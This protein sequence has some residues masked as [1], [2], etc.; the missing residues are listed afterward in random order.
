MPV[1][2]ATQ[3]YSRANVSQ[4]F[5]SRF[6][7]Y[8]SNYDKVLEK[9]FPSAMHIYRVFS[10]GVKD[11]FGDMKMYFKINSIVNGKGIK[12]LT[13]KEMELYCQM[14]K[15]M[16]KVAPVLLIAALPFMNYVIFPIAYMYPRKLLTSHFWTIQQRVE[17]QE[18]Y[19][20]ERT[21][22]NKKLFRRLQ[23][24]LDGTKDSP[25][26]K[27]FNYMLGLLGSGTHPTAEE[28][29]MVKDVFLE[30]PYSL[31]SLSSSHLVSH[32]NILTRAL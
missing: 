5:F 20:K 1:K 31:K 30:A 29:L 13:R 7:Q 6:F 16:L 26:H 19:L 21:A 8:I 23:L 24:G 2:D 32:E 22:N 12:A 4:Y 3:K 15:D 28:I 27:E 9:K 14:P 18:L 25:Y 11:F 17:F 10:L